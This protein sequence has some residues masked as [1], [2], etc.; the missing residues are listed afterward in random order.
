[1]FE[2]IDV[3]QC[4]HADIRN[5]PLYTAS[6]EVGGGC[7]FGE[8]ERGCAV[9]RGDRQ[10]ASLV[11]NL[12]WKQRNWFAEWRSH[13]EARHSRENNRQLDQ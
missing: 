1:M 9:A 6:H 4:R 7:A 12:R 3:Q 5:C 13:V 8:L 11:A 10:Y 2:I